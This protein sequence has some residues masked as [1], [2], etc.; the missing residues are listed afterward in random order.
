MLESRLWGGQFMT[1]NV[2]LYVCVCVCEAEMFS[3][4]WCMMDLTVLSCIQ[5][6]SDHQQYWLECSQK[7]W[8]GLQFGDGHVL[9][10]VPHHCLLSAAWDTLGENISG[11]S[12]LDPKLWLSHSL[13]LT[14][15]LP[16]AC[17]AR[18]VV[19]RWRPLC[20]V[21]SF[22]MFF[23]LISVA[24]MSSCAQLIIPSKYLMTVEHM[25]HWVSV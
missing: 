11:I 4:W 12:A 9:S 10:P 25:C 14:L 20:T 17:K 21:W 18:V 1:D 24:S 3:R 22:G 6:W 23:F 13:I 7:P 8:Q 19:S 15:R 2:P 16:I 5:L